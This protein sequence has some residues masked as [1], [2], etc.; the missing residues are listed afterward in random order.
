MSDK[1]MRKEITE[2][3]VRMLVDAQIK[4]NESVRV[5][6]EA[7]SNLDKIRSLVLDANGIPP[8]ALV[9]LDAQSH[10]LVYQEPEEKDE[11]VIE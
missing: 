4:H 10:E 2:L 11:E 7:K 9:R 8:E 3:Q 5:F 6:Q 1:E